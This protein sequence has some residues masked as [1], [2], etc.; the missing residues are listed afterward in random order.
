MTTVATVLW[1]VGVPLIVWGLLSIARAVRRVADVLYEATKGNG[2]PLI[3]PYGS[4]TPSDP[5]R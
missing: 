2:R 5:R 3:L 1:I 4:Q